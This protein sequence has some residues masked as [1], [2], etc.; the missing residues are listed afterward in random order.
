[1]VRGPRRAPGAATGVEEDEATGPVGVLGHARPL[2]GLAEQCRLLVARD[3]GHRDVAAEDAGPAIDLCRG[4]RL[5]QAGW[6]DSKQIAELRVPSKPADVEQHR[7]RGVRVVG[8]MAAGELEDEPRVD[9]P[10]G[11]AASRLDVPPKPF[12]LRGREVGVD[13]QPR[14][15]PHKRFMPG[16]LELVAARRRAAVLPDER[17]VDGLARLGVPGD[18]RLALV[19]DPDRV[20][21]GALDPRV[22][23]RLRADPAGHL[24]DLGRVVLHPTGLREVL[25]EL[26]V[27]ASGDPALAVEDEAGGP[28]RALVDGEDQQ[29]PSLVA[30]RLA[31][32]GRSLGVANRR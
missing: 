24:P 11:G 8:D 30:P 1:M 31:E 20:Q 29:A 13:D 27:G 14:A 2:A 16:G 26:R 7:P 23:D 28:G 17:V 21:L 9:R 4:N 3:P 25:L 18:H 6:I 12:D 32:G 5:G 22:H 15:L 10:E 19:G